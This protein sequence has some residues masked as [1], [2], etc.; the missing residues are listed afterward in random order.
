MLMMPG[1]SGPSHEHQLSGC[2][3]LLDGLMA[4]FPEHQL[5]RLLGHL[6]RPS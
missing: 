3:A 1:L 2:F 4:T 6:T 5:F